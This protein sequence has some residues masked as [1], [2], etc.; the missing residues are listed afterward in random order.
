MHFGVFSSVKQEGK[1]GAVRTVKAYR[2]VEVQHL[3]FFT[4][5]VDGM[6]G[7]LHAPAALPLT[8]EGVLTTH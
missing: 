3:S 1:F 8:V 6:S 5:V 7:R 2:G 4:F